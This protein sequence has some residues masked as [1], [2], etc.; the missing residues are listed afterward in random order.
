[1]PCHL[2]PTSS[3]FGMGYT[4]DYIVYHEL[5]M[6]TKVSLFQ[7]SL[8]DCRPTWLGQ[9]FVITLCRLLGWVLSLGGLRPHA[10]LAGKLRLVF[11]WGFGEVYMDTQ[12]TSRFQ[13]PRLCQQDCFLLAAAD[14]QALLVLLEGFSEGLGLFCWTIGAFF[15]SMEEFGWK[16]GL[17]SQCLRL[18]L[19]FFSLT[20]LG[21][22]PSHTAP[23]CG[24]A[25]GGT[26]QSIGPS[27]TTALWPFCLQEY[28][29]CVTAVDGEW[30]AELG[31]MF[32]SVKQA[33][34]S[35]QVRILCFSMED[36]LSLG[37]A[38]LSAWY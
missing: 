16:K 18:S 6:T 24:T 8:Y 26:A 29:Q 11:S 23:N 30:L 9:A 36:L 14:K 7:G 28:M 3:L 20:G 2:H 5:V 12:L 34:K 17:E 27:V 4:P 25:L 22:G 19:A 21:V 15:S 35:R 38:F 1:M 13:W 10:L 37:S 33:G 32:Y 31:P